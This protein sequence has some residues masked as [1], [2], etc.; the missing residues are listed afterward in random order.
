MPKKMR[1]GMLQVPE[2]TGRRFET[3]MVATEVAVQERWYYRKWLRH[4]L[5]FC[6]KYGRLPS[7]EASLEAF[8]EKLASKN[9]SAAQR[10]QA[11]QAVRLYLGMQPRPGST[12]ARD[13][14]EPLGVQEGPRPGA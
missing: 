7:E 3:T 10:Q 11:E 4:Y 12:E 1:C 8:L 14:R 2:E 13:R 6:V 9:Q 5:D